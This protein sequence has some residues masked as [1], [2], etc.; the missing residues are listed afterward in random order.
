MIIIN[1]CSIFVIILLIVL[2]T[3]GHYVCLH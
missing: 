2:P 1:E 3:A